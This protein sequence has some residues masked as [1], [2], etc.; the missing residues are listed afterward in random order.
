MKL[1]LLEWTVES[2]DLM[3]LQLFAD[4]LQSR[5][6]YCKT[7][8][9]PLFTNKRLNKDTFTKQYYIFPLSKIIFFVVLSSGR[10]CTAFVKFIA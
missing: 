6:L 7:L 1:F 3:A 5:G 2:F 10:P 8:R 4:F 9:I